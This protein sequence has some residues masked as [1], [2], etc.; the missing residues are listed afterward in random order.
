MKRKSASNITFH[1]IASNHCKDIRRLQKM[2][3][4]KRKLPGNFKFEMPITEGKK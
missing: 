1:N 3:E 4:T 2:T